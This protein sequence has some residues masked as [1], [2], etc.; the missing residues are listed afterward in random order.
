MP[1]QINANKS[2]G[3]KT[4]HYDD[5]MCLLCQNHNYS[6]RLICN[7]RPTQATAATSRPRNKMPT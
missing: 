4:A 3:Q 7:S 5:W 6:F 1:E 2:N